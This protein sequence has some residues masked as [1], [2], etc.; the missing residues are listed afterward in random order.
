[1]LLKYH[2]NALKF[3]KYTSP[4]IALGTSWTAEK[5]IAQLNSKYG[6]KVILNF[7]VGTDDKN[8]VNHIIHVSLCGRQPK[9]SL[10]CNKTSTYI[11]TDI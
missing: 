11:V 9:L 2:I 8:S 7:F 3:L 4:F 5:A 6:K 1:M 10:N